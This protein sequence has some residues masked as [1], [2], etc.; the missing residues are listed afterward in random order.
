MVRSDAYSASDGSGVRICGDEPGI[1]VCVSGSV[2][3]VHGN[4]LVIEDH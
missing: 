3:W 1:Q 2:F 4:Q